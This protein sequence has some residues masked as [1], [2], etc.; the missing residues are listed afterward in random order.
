PGSTI[1]FDTGTFSFDR[2]LSLTVGGVTI[3]GQGQDKTILSFKGQTTGAQGLYVNLHGTS[4]AM[5]D[6]AVED[7]KGDCVKVEGAVGVK[8]QPVRTEWTNGPD[9]N[10]GSYGIYPVQSK[11]ILIEDC[12]ARGASDTGIYVGQSEDIVVRRNRVEGNVAG[13][14]IENS[15]RAD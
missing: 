13:I 7:T 2:D 9:K 12:F 1:V 8:F 10:N 11:Q 3:A 6:I 15:N 5:R 14:E 4:F